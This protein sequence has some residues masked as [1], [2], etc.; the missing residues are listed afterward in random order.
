MKIYGVASM[1]Q[2]RQAMSIATLAE[3]K[4]AWA[5]DGEMA[6]LE[7]RLLLSYFYF[8]K[9]ELDEHIP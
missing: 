1:M 2:G 5:H 6:N 4:A 9:H 8:G 3:G 7:M